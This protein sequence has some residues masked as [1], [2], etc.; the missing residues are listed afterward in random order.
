[1]EP[2]IS[3]YQD[4]NFQ[5]DHGHK[6]LVEDVRKLFREANDHEFHDYKSKK[7]PMP[8]V[9]LVATLERMISRVKAGYYNNK[10]I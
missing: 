8:K 4:E 10:N 9:A 3:P 1:M 5:I 2:V 7:Y 6:G